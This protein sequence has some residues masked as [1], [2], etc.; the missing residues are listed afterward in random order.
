MLSSDLKIFDEHSSVAA[1]MARYGGIVDE[2]VIVVVGAGAPE[3]KQVAPNVRAVAPGGTDKL[4]IFFSARRALHTLTRDAKYD[5]VSAQDPFFIGILGSGI[6]KLR[7]I[8]LQVQLHTDCF[9]LGFLMESPRRMLEALI[10]T[11]ILNRAQCIR[12]VSERIAKSVR[13]ITRVPVIVLPIRTEATARE[14]NDK[15][16]STG[17]LKL[18]CVSRLTSEKRI[19]LIIDAIATVPQAELVI[20]GDGPLKKTLESRVQRLRLEERVHFAGWQNPETYYAE[21]DAFVHASRY[22]GYGVVLM[23][24]ALAGLAIITTD[25]G[26]VGEVLQDEESALVIPGNSG[27]IASAI[28]RIVEDAP[29]RTRL[30]NHAQESASSHALSMEEYLLRYQRALRGC[31]T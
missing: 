31:T 27:A 14:R 10:A 17:A 28:R 30:G 29:L 5:L 11:F 13:K 9:S 16:L 24:A 3:E 23:E 26:I 25:V 21:A 7:K 20:V 12:V 18:L 8:P 6:A 19:H 15:T 2:M 4:A 22:E 1:R